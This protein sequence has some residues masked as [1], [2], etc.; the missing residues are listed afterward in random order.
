MQSLF[1]SKML[2][3]IFQKYPNFYFLFFNLFTRFF[4][5]A[6][7]AYVTIELINI[8]AD[9]T[10]DKIS[11]FRKCAW[12]TVGISILYTSILYYA[13]TQKIRKA[14][15]L[16]RR[17]MEM[18]PHVLAKAIA[19]LRA[20]PR[21][22]SFFEFTCVFLTIPFVLSVYLRVFRGFSS[23]EVFEVSIWGSLGLSVT[24]LITY[25]LNQVFFGLPKRELLAEPLS[26]DQYS[27]EYE[28]LVFSIIFSRFF[29]SFLGGVLI[30]YY[31]KA[32]AQLNDLQFFQFKFIAVLS[33]YLTIIYTALLHINRTLPF[34]KLL[35]KLANLIPTSDQEKERGIYAASRFAANTFLLEAFLPQMTT[36]IPCVLYLKFFYDVSSYSLMQLIFGAAAGSYLIILFTYFTF[37]NAINPI[38]KI[39]YIEGLPVH[40]IPVPKILGLRTRM[41]LS[42]SIILIIMASMIGM[43]AV[44]SH[45]MAI[46]NSVQL[47]HE[48]FMISL[49][50]LAVSLSLFIMLAKTIT[51]PIR[52]IVESMEKIK[53]GDLSSP[54]ISFQNDEIGVLGRIFNT[55]V[56]Q[57][58]A[59]RE[60][61]G[62]LNRN[63]EQKVID[64]TQELQAAN[65]QLKTLDKLKNDLFANISHEFRTPLTTIR[66]ILAEM[67]ADLHGITGNR[68][69]EVIT[70]A[71]SNTDRLLVLISGI[72]DLAKFK[73]GRLELHL[74]PTVLPTQLREIIRRHQPYH[75]KKPSIQLHIQGPEPFPVVYLDQAKFDTIISNLL[76]NALKF[77]AP[78]AEDVDVILSDG[79]DTIQIIVRDFGEGISADKLDKIFDRFY[80]A[81]EKSAKGTGLGLSMVKGYTELHEGEVS[82]ESQYGKGTTFY[83][84]FKKGDRWFQNS[85]HVYLEKAQINLVHATS[86]ARDLGGLPPIDRNTIYEDTVRA[87][88]RDTILIIDDEPDIA[89]TLKRLL[90]EDYNLIFAKEGGEGLV[91]MK[92]AK[93][94]LVLSDVMMQ[95]VGGFELLEAARREESIKDIPVILLTAAQGEQN[96]I[97]GFK[98]GA[99]DY[100]T[101]PFLIDELRMRIRNQL[102]ILKDRR[103]IERLSAL[104]I[105][106]EKLATLSIYAGSIA[107]NIRNMMLPF[108]SAFDVLE[109]DS[110]EMRALPANAATGQLNDYCDEI[111]TMIA[112]AKTAVADIDD[113]I[114][115]LLTIYTPDT[116]G[117]QLAD[118]SD[119]IQKAIRLQKTRQLFDN[120]MIH[121]DAIGHDFMLAVEKGLFSSNI[122]E[123]L[124][125][126]GDAIAQARSPA[127]GNIWI[128]LEAGA[129]SVTLS[130]KD[131][132]CGMSAEVKKE[133]F[134][135][136]YTTKAA[137][138]TGLG[139][140]A[141]YQMVQRHNGI[142]EVE[143]DVG[144]GTAFTLTLP[145]QVPA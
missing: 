102:T 143:S 12:I 81:T 96:L 17:R 108:Q 111:E 31:V 52:T 107:H 19:D 138:G 86:P 92:T 39:F 27:E 13:W 33:I 62:T 121:Y 60:E 71:V 46:G 104:L 14:L 69:D 3:P 20:L 101:K 54:P 117:R 132:G 30:I 126:A 67:L 134:A 119:L 120:I 50:L 91:K 64:R 29:P 116:A 9:L 115:A 18:P 59:S 88:G 1:L 11:I 4:P 145:K 113:L 32:N 127:R 10:A 72:L 124:K 68:F 70:S 125:N 56:K 28:R 49:A 90:K 142:I 128:R 42:S 7:G 100:I 23:Y 109:T 47:V 130:V 85:D 131:D 98:E 75:G 66:S 144:K 97:I 51:S 140:A 74:A 93:P 48:I 16:K 78:G 34:K 22:I 53:A 55:M 65:E 24:T 118:I 77:S 35:D 106:S 44:R 58:R 40:A 25:K 84:S 26:K 73:Q 95:P 114:K 21:R 133:I 94:D 136:L 15:S 43:V 122:V 63:L 82:V 105:Q 79:L 45:T 36:I 135:P 141:V 61:L 6:L 139:L 5:S 112:T 76:G 87:E 38:L 41:L 99:R 80:Q 2:Q 103:R 110:Q 8:G 57:L 137:L 37:E 83:L 129:D 123:L 89:A